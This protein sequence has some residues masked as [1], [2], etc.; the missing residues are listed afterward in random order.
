M[1]ILASSIVNHATTSHQGALV[2]EAVLRAINAN[3][4]VELSLRGISVVSS[5][6]SNALFAELLSSFQFDLLQARL[7]I[8]NSNST[9]ND[10]LRRSLSRALE[11]TKKEKELAA[12]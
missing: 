7:E 10:V 1:V 2:A 11:N 12:S 3:K 4:K 5:S 8:T 9:I 6:F